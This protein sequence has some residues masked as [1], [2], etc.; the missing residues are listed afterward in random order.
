M[1]GDFNL[2][3]HALVFLNHK[4]DYQNSEQLA[5]NICTNPARVRKVLSALKKASLV[6]TREG[7]GGG[8]RFILPPEQVTLCQVADALETRLVSAGKASGSVDMECLIASGMGALMDELSAELEQLCRE[9]LKITTI[10]DMDR[11]IFG[12][13]QKESKR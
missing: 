13:G 12:D 3:V 11:R 10:A 7:G 6:E 5:E 4:G 2:G 8:F 1:T 9:R